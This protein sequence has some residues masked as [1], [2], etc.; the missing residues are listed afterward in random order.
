MLTTAPCATAPYSWPDLTRQ[1]WGEAV[2]DPTPGIIVERPR[3]T[4]ARI[5]RSLGA[6]LQNLAAFLMWG[7]RPRHEIEAMAAEER[8]PM[9]DVD[10]A[11]WLLEVVREPENGVEQWRLTTCEAR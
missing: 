4:T 3:S 2:D 6:A 1:R 10:R 9:A 11:A 7:P 5:E 8:L